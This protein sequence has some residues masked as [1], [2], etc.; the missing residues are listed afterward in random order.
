MHSWKKSVTNGGHV[1]GE[2]LTNCDI[3]SE[4]N[5]FLQ[6]VWLCKRQEM[7]ILVAI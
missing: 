6:Y 1:R 7:L 5:A 2:A 3:Q 4:Y